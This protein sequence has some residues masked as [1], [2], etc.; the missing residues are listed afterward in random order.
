MA[1][2]IKKTINELLRLLYNKAAT[3]EDL[4]NINF[5]NPY[6]IAADGTFLG[7]FSNKFNSYSIFNEFGTY[8]S[9]FSGHSIFN[10]FGTYGSKFS[11]YSPYNEFTQMAPKIFYK[12]QEIGYLTKNRFKQN[13]ID[14]DML[15]SEL[16]K[17][18]MS[19]VNWHFLFN[20]L[21]NRG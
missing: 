19:Y 11:I 16:N 10:E 2:K 13:S 12:N 4:N 17:R 14:P 18:G 20:E 5:V 21:K 1:E 6:L 7:V 3:Q 9:K 15:F 8:G